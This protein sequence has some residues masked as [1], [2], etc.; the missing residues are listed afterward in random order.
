MTE[1]VRGH[2]REGLRM[3]PG[4]SAWPVRDYKALLVAHDLFMAG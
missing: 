2:G 4:V 3:K 1:R